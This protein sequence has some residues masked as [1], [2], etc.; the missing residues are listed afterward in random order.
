MQTR[1]KGSKIG[2]DLKLSESDDGVGTV[3]LRGTKVVD[4]KDFN[5]VDEI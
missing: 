5:N 1:G 4:E 2:D 3:K